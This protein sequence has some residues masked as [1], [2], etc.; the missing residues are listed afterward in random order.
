MP[1]PA[2]PPLPNNEY[3]AT[4]PNL[5]PPLPLSLPTPLSILLPL[6][7]LQH[8][9][10]QP[11][12]KPKAK[13][14]P[15]GTEHRDQ[16]DGKPGLRTWWQHITTTQKPRPH[17]STENAHARS[18]A[19]ALAQEYVPPPP[20][21]VFGRPLKDSLR[22]ASVQISTADAMGR[23]YVWGYIPVVVA[24]WCVL[25]H[26]LGFPFLLL[27]AVAFLSPEK[28]S[29]NVHCAWAVVAYIVACS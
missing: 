28:K 6:P 18:K 8:Q 3:P 26:F 27:S 11:K 2:S 21:A 9:Q 17:A 20:G 16:R 23:L 5:H 14:K 10:P 29:T 22:Y 13:P 19:Q 12:P 24:K 7:H 1:A 4:T 25:V 15:M